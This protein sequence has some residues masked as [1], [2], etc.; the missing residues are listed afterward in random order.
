[1]HVHTKTYTL[2]FIDALFII[3]KTGNHP[4]GHQTEAYPC[5][6]ILLSDKEVADMYRRM[7][8]SQKHF[9]N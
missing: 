1:M 6:G 9:V 2:T 8:A 7:A 4:N 5:H 3:V